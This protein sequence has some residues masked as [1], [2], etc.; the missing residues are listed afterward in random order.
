MEGRKLVW[1]CAGFECLVEEDREGRGVMVVVVVV[2]V[3]VESWERVI[4]NCE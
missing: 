4:A 1:T 3:V 2:V